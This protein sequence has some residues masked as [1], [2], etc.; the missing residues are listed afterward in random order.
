MEE[1]INVQASRRG[2]SAK[3]WRGRAL[4]ERS[5]LALR[6]A[7]LYV[8]GYEVA[9]TCARGQ[10]TTLPARLHGLD[11]LYQRSLDIGRSIEAL[12]YFGTGIT[13]GCDEG[14]DTLIFNN[15]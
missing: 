7:A 6:R 10:P 14:S 9:V 1:D 2:G 11:R 4:E 8:I 13:E 15:S 12:E 3:V 5:R